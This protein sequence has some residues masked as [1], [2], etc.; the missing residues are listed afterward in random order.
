MNES[1]LMTTTVTGDDVAAVTMK[2]EEAIIG[3]PRGHAI[4]ALLSMILIL[5]KPDITMEEMGTQVENISRYI[6]LS[7]D[8]TELRVVDDPSKLN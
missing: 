6:C 4:V 7:L 1:T 8:D 2:I 5:M 3:T